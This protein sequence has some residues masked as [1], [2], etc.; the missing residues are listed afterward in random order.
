MT[1]SLFA[2]VDRYI[3]DLFAPTDAALEAALTKAREAGM[4]AIQISAGQGKLLYLLARLIGARRI[5]EIGTL[6]G[7]STIWLGR[8][9]AGDGRLISLE[10]DPTHA[11]VA[12]ANIAGAGL[13]DRVDIRTGPALDSLRAIPSR[14]SFDLVFIDAD[15]GGY[16][17]YLEEAL[18]L[19]RPG[20][21]ILGDNVIRAGK[22]VEGESG[23]PAVEGARRFNEALA[24]ENRVEAIILQQ[25]G[26]KGHDGLAI[27]RVKD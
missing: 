16:V 22:V 24:A 18:R 21:L 7:Y 11:D 13:A 12:R 27:A 25:V 9:L 15:K 4:P 5:L 19:T 8:A 20:G 10:V 2:E 26:V 14:E 3:D 17:D 1:D 23:N 6:A